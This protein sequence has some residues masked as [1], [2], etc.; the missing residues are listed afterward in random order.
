MVNGAVTAVPI[1]CGGEH[2]H[3]TNVKSAP[4][5]HVLEPFNFG[6]NVMALT[7]LNNMESIGNGNVLLDFYTSNC[8]PCRTLN[9]LLEE[10]ANEYKNLMVA[11]VEVT[12]NPEASQK[13]GIMSVPTVILMV[14]SKVK[15]VSQGNPGREALRSMVKR[16]VIKA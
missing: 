16:H 11:K 2:L 15:E 5:P 9:P 4:L 3:A 13:F 12:K 10:I 1:N 6:G 7:E 14:N 8:A